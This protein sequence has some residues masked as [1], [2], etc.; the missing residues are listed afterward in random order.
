MM[1]RSATVS[2]VTYRLNVGRSD[3]GIIPLGVIALLADDAA[4]ASFLV[5]VARPELKALER[6]QMDWAAAK[7]LA[8]PFEF[9]K[10][11]VDSVLSDRVS[12]DVLDRISRKLTWSIH[13]SPPAEIAISTELATD[14]TNALT[15]L[16][17]STKRTLTVD[18]ANI[19]IQ[20]RPRKA[21]S[22]LAHIAGPEFRGEAVRAYAPPAWMLTS[23]G[24]AQPQSAP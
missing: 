10:T 15:I 12:D 1:I 4:A 19:R 7:L 23:A 2:K 11:Q 18:N 8:N 13:A 3:G 22:A 14:L 16:A 6:N 24:T 9:L 5:L 20:K 17:A 21:P